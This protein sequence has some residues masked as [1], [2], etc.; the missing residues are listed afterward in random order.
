M[1]KNYS[2]RNAYLR[3]AFNSQFP[4]E[5]FDGQGA[6]AMQYSLTK[7]QGGPS[8]VPNILM[9]GGERDGVLYRKEYCDF[10]Y[11]FQNKCSIDLADF[12]VACGHV[13]VDK[14]RIPDKPYVL[15]MGAYG[16]PDG[17]DVTCEK[18]VSRDGKA[19]A[20]I[21]SS[22]WGQIALTIY[23]GFEEIQEKER[24]GLSPAAEVSRLLC[25]V[26][27]RDRWYAYEPYVMVSAVLTNKTGEAWT[28]EE[29][30]PVKSIAFTDP[31]GCGGYGPV[32]LTLAD[33]RVMTVDYEGME[34]RLMI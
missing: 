32:A 18:R 2:S 5:D 7:A 21:L 28:E 23:T 26:S 22:S 4:W 34:G 19:R 9:Y 16:M 8:Q 15:T 20:V 30:F 1:E 6:E 25:A 24:K 31:E 11:T 12:P 3:L 13:R 27:R 14:A 29:L 10:E 33:G 17:G